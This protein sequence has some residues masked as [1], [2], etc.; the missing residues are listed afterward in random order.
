MA[1]FNIPILSSIEGSIKGRLK[2]IE[3]RIEKMAANVIEKKN[4]EPLLKQGSILN[5]RY[6]IEEFSKKDGG[7]QCVSCH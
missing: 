3:N 6:R 5:N 7:L 2:N 4:D 1:I